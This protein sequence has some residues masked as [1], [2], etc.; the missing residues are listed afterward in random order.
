M[1]NK[2]RRIVLA[3]AKALAI[4]FVT[5][6]VIGAFMGAW[7]ISFPRLP[8]SSLE[9]ASVKEL[10]AKLAAQEGDASSSEALGLIEFLHNDLVEARTIVDGVS[11]RRPPSLA[12][13]DAALRVKEARATLD[14]LFGQLKLTHLQ[15]AVADL[16]RLSRENAD[17]VTIQVLALSTF[18]AN[19][20]LDVDRDSTEQIAKA[21][22]QRLKTSSVPV[23][24][25][26]LGWLAI[27]QVWNNSAT[28]G[29][30]A[31]R[32]S[33]AIGRDAALEAFD[34]LSDKPAWLLAE[35]GALKETRG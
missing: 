24:L 21:L 13:V 34:A 22:D 17:D 28:A 6:N 35:R 5:G 8:M 27:A 31:T 26:G 3:I 29:A 32:Q 15:A 25:G 11:G 19:P 16:E 23:E 14:L 10:R 20:D 2:G 4:T 33:A 7:P 12:A 1:Q 18:A 30:G 9:E